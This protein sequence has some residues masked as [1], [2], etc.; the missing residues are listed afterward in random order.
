MN[1]TSLQPNDPPCDAIKQQQQ[2]PAVKEILENI[3]REIDGPEPN[4]DEY[5]P[6]VDER[7]ADALALKATIDPVTNR[8][9]LFTPEEF[10]AKQ[11]D[12][13]KKVAERISDETNFG[14]ALEAWVVQSADFYE[15][16]LSQEDHR[17]SMV[18][19]M[20][21]STEDDWKEVCEKMFGKLVHLVKAKD[22]YAARPQA[23]NGGSLDRDASHAWKNLFA[24]L[25]RSE[26]FFMRGMRA[27]DWIDPTL[28]DL[29][30]RRAFEKIVPVGV[31]YDHA[32]ILASPVREGAKR[33]HQQDDK[34][35][36]TFYVARL[37]A[38][39]PRY[40][41]HRTAREN[42]E[43]IEQK[44]SRR[45]D[46]YRKANTTCYSRASCGFFA[47]PDHV[48]IHGN[49]VSAVWTK[50]PGTQPVQDMLRIYKLPKL[51]A[52]PSDMVTL[53]FPDGILN[54]YEIH[55]PYFVF[56]C[57][58]QYLFDIEWVRRL[59]NIGDFASVHD[60]EGSRDF[61]TVVNLQTQV[62]ERTWD[63]P[64]TVTYIGMYPPKNSVLCES[65]DPKHMKV[66]WS[67]DDSSNPQ[68]AYHRALFED[69]ILRSDDGASRE[70]EMR[71][72]WRDMKD[73]VELKRAK[74]ITYKSPPN[75]P[76]RAIHR[77]HGDHTVMISENNFST[78]VCTSPP[79]FPTN[80]I[81]FG[82][83]QVILNRAIYNNVCV[84]MYADYA[85]GFSCIRAP[86]ANKALHTVS[87]F[88][89]KEL[90]DWG[91]SGGKVRPDPAVLR[92]KSIWMSVDRIAVLFQDGTLVFLNAMSEQEVERIRHLTA[93]MRKNKATK[94]QLQDL[95]QKKV[96]SAA[97]E[98]LKK[99]SPADAKAKNVT[100]H[101]DMEQ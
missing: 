33:P 84:T 94:M 35:H 17:H 101:Q 29:F 100:D 3:S 65:I 82:R 26:Q 78:L 83:D 49:R 61:I 2:A 67:C 56:S 48:E 46:E 59:R 99:G 85:I 54:H 86:E 71:P 4:D 15:R 53:M 40:V 58:N 91:E 77:Y 97:D 63:V 76:P 16:E 12:I 47:R 30:Q 43:A 36:F 9:S 51:L 80:E 73:E 39:N 19:K 66:L 37:T 28:D 72:L 18:V 96:Y 69:H 64:G 1:S 45:L 70:M 52:N 8:V 27:P 5:D 24:W 11:E 57:S 75:E 98:E 81:Y 22:L 13:E 95:V 62:I 32:V 93:A 14:K 79:L 92:Y 74:N 88:S 6:E 10:R 34:A 90:E 89:L 31:G 25:S 21:P 38:N 55:W 68:S 23:G 41:N 20:N 44:D 60:Q 87:R 50:V 42:V 7:L